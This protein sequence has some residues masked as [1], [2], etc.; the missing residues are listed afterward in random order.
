MRNPAKLIYSTLIA[1]GAIALAISIIYTS[2]ILAFI[3]LGLVFWGIIFAY[4]RTEEYTKKVLLDATASPQMAT[5][6]QIIQELEYK[7]NA[8]YL[9]PKYLKDPE[10]NK[11]YISKQK[12]TSLPAP[13]QIQKQETR[14]FI[15]NPLSIL[16]TPPGAGLARLFEKT[17][18][19]NF[20]R[21]DLQYLQRNMPNL[22]I[23]DL[24]I[25]QNF[26]MEIENNK[27][28][29]KIENSVYSA[30]NIETE[31]PSSTYFL[32]GSPLSS[33]I[34]CALAKTTGKPII[35]E[36]QQTSEDG[37]D[38]TIEYRILEEEEQTEA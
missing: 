37:G 2:S 19:T 22:F 9:P 30:L 31:Q 8:I 16:L 20:T 13:E 38:V 14:F 7:G 11:A 21:V 32:F 15:E 17:F 35:I 5:L 3:G 36:K 27:I 34:A 26:E 24:E 28:R 12:E 1:T 33:A 23:E 25:A 6:N 18:K 4:I 29:V 10:A